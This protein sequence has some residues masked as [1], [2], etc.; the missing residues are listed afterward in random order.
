LEVPVGDAANGGSTPPHANS[1]AGRGA[2]GGYYDRLTRWTAFAQAFGYGGGHDKLAV[3]RALADPRAGGRQSV[4]R[5][6]D[7]LLATLPAPPSGRVLDAGCG[8]GGT[9]LDLAGRC[10]ARFTGITLSAQQAAVGRA[11]AAKAGFAE[12]VA[13][14]VGSYD[15]PPEGP[16]ELA[17]A[18]E[19]LAHS[20]HPETS[21]DAIAA[22]L[23]PHGTLAIADDMPEPAARG[24]RD[25]ELFHSGWRVPMLTGAAELRS[26][27][28]RRGL[29]IVADRDLTDELRPRTLARIARLETLNRWLH[30]LTP[31]A[32]LRELLDSYRGGLALERLYRAGLMRYRLIVAEKLSAR[33]A[34]AR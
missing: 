14:H 25:L 1:A 28:A 2:L 8:L 20:P 17:I 30:R 7:V 22:R 34:S 6:H 16:F 3:H 31:S 10:S 5:L 29:A 21:I 33:P 32:G 19:S 9:M 27:L 23:A 26:M 18:I 4:T 11:A 12:R 24:T 13:F 15:S